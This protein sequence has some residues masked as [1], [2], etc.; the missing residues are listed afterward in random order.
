MKLLLLSV[1]TLIL[2]AACHSGTPQLHSR[3][4]PENTASDCRVIEHEG[5]E[6]TICGQPQKVVA[7]SPPLLDILLALGVQPAGYAEVDLLN[8]KVF[9]RPSQ[10]I[11]YLGKFVM[12][13]P[14]NL[15]DRHNPSIET[16]LQLKPDLILGEKFYL[17]ENYKLF[18]RIAP[19]AFFQTEGE[20]GWKYVMPIMAQ[21]LN[22]E[23][24]AQ[25]A[26][27]SHNQ[28]VRTAK[29]QLAPVVSGQTIIVLGWQPTSNQSFIFASGFITG[30]L[31][32]LGFRVIVGEPNRPNTSIEAIANIKA[33]YILI[34]PSGDNTISNAQQ[35]WQND[36]ILRLIPAA[37]AGK[38]YF[39]DYQITRIRGPIAAEVFINQMQQL[40][41]PN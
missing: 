30:L 8:T 36:P 27:A 24:Q 6:T 5:G 15:G 26:I 37:Q 11:P 13:Q 7:L 31:E 9:D 22:R 14:V 33:D 4:T 19:T 17:E 21:A 2:A 34:M 16:L 29:S 40:L 23:E 41:Q 38:I 25:R 3:Q 10:Q 18:S 32:D 39:M 35:Q 1:C 28:L 20:T 12:G